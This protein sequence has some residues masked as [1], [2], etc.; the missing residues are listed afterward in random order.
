MISQRHIRGEH[1]D[2]SRAGSVLS[3]DS[4]LH[5][6]ILLLVYILDSCGWTVFRCSCNSDSEDD[7][8]MMSHLYSLRV[9][10]CEGKSQRKWKWLLTF[11]HTVLP[12]YSSH[13]WSIKRRV[14]HGL[15]CS[16]TPPC[17]YSEGSPS[18]DLRGQ[19]INGTQHCWNL[20]S[21]F[22]SGNSGKPLKAHRG[23][24]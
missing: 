17:C 14:C 19:M 6:V 5:Y 9:I 18:A 16:L 10:V 7:L 24:W 15:C 12:S 2:C 4:T 8:L 1:C 22:V 13:M 21:H 20:S 3:T 11:V 23:L